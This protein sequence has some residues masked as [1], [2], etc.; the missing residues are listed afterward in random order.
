MTNVKTLKIIVSI[1]KNAPI[2]LG[3]KDSVNPTIHIKAVITTA[4][5]KLSK[6]TC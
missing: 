3:E 1:D 6:P 4:T 2:S 5:I